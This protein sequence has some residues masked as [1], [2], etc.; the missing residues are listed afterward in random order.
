VPVA[1]NPMEALTSWFRA[2][3]EFTVMPPFAVP[4]V[5]DWL[6]PVPMV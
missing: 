4:S 3:V 5:N 1:D 2:T 6:V